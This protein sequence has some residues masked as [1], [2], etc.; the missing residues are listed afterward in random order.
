MKEDGGK[1]YYTDKYH[2][3]PAATAVCT[4]VDKGSCSCEFLRTS[5]N[6]V[7]AFP[8]TANT[9]HVP[10]VV[11][12]QP[13]AELTA[14]EER[15]PLVNFGESGPLRCTRCHAYVNPYFQWQSGGREATCN[16]CSHRVQVPD[17]YYFPLDDHGR[18]KDHD[19]RPE[20]Q[21][22]TV[23]YVAPRDYSDSLPG[24]PVM[25]FVIEASQRSVQS[26]L[27]PQVTWTL[28]SLMGFIEAPAR[29]AI[30]TFDSSLHF[31]AF[32]PGLDCARAV[33]VS[34]ME[35]PFVPCS[36]SALCVNVEDDAYRGQIEALLEELPAAFADAAA[37]QVAGGSALRAAVDLVGAAGGGHVMMFHSSLPN[38]GLGALRH[39]D[40]LRLAT[41]PDEGGLFTVQQAP[42]FDGVAA[43]CLSRGVAVSVFCAPA[44]G[45][46]ID[47]ASLSSVPRRTGGEIHYLPGFDPVRDGER[48]HY[49]LSRTV[50]QGSVYSCIFK[51]RC[52]KGLAVDNMY[53]T[54]E[55]EVIDQSTFHASRLGV[56]A[57][58]DFVISHSERIEGQ[59]NV[60]I[61]VACLHTDRRGQR[62]IR[63]STLQLPVTSSLSNVFRYTEI[64]SVTNLLLKQAASSALSGNGGFKDKLVKSCVDMLH[65]YRANCAS[66]TSAGQLI[67]PESLKL[68]PLFIGS[69]RKMAAF[70]SG[71]DIRV[72]DRVSSLVR[73]LGLPIAQTAPLVYPRVFTLW[74]LTERAGLP[75]EVGENVHMPPTIACSSDKLASDRVYLIDNG[76]ALRIYVREEV[77]PDVLLNLFGTDMLH[78]VPA[79]LGRPAEDLSLDARRVFAIVQQI[80]RER[81]RLP[82]QPLLIVLPGTPEEA[83]LMSMICEDRVAGEMNYVDFLCHV[84]RMVQNKQD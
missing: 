17:E 26:G 22:G 21:K 69:I 29:I 28:R 3:P 23:D 59:K 44:L 11:V 82:W 30:I 46:Y 36:P 48:L 75:T 81:I 66:M 4:I 71:S 60:Y 51:L 7:P 14:K 72:D 2:I 74:P 65:A 73:M 25:C 18:R 80:R 77:P 35:D 13:F 64:D 42:F 31:Y 15:V 78:E 27:L 53:A 76:M 9:A 50:V 62:L 8:S 68:L 19:D 49:D 47:M 20:L 56:D 16:F 43:D 32:Y 1:V 37:E 79:A 6:Q 57:T 10:I 63:I 58:A 41:K 61:Q 84:H 5:V 67:L 70:R 33:T 52:S 39:R 40:D 38:T 55:P 45:A 83:R 34:D 54:W 12:C 24:V